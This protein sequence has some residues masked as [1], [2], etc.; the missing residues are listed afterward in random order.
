MRAVCGR[1]IAKPLRARSGPLND[2][3]T[4]GFPALRRR[5]ADKFIYLGKQSLQHA[6]AGCRPDIARLR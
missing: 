5:F 4:Y 2:G 1:I 6:A 3:L